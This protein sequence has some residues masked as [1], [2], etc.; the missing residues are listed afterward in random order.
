MH[1][2]KVG[3][4][5]GGESPEKEISLASAKSVE[6]SMQNMN[7]NYKVFQAD[8]DF[9][10]EIK[11]SDIDVVFIAMHG[12]KGE[13]GVVQGMLDSLGVPYTGSGVFASALCMNK[14]ICKQ[15]LRVN[16][17]KT[18]AW[19]MIRN[20][21]EIQ[22][23]L[24]AVIKPV[25]GGSTVGTYIVRDKNKL[26]EAVGGALKAASDGTGNGS[27]YVLAEE[28]VP[29]RE[30]TVGILDRRSLPILEIES[31][32]EFYDYTAKYEKGMSKHHVVE[33]IEGTLYSRIQK[34]AEDVFKLMNC[35]TM[36]RID[37]RLDKEDFYILEINTIPGMTQTSLL[38]E[39]A[40]IAGIDFDAL[41]LKILESAIQKDK[42]K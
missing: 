20:S 24:P 15:I 18:P 23:G 10:N 29:G 36:A 37:Y 11:N 6:I 9:L 16:G 41:I 30:I 38:P 26:Q 34:S 22:I 4:L 12:G 17:Y 7:I 35:K 1:I 14:A 8:G 19:Q 42:K 31:M 2:G 32:T 13:N 3:L 5:T 28:Y 39:A 25:S 27:E 40:E 33:D 21:Q